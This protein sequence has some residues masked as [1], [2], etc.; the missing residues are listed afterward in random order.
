LSI[1]A[2]IIPKKGD[3]L[4]LWAL[5]EDE[6]F[7]RTQLPDHVIVE[8][9]SFQDPLRRTQWLAVR[10]LLK[11]MGYPFEISYLE[12]GQ[13]QID[14]HCLSIS[15]T[16]KMVGVYVSLEKQGLDLE[17]PHPRI[18]RIAQRFMNTDEQKRFGSSDLDV[19]T[20]IW[21][22]KEALFKKY[23]EETTFFAS[24]Q[25]VLSINHETHELLTEVRLNGKTISE[26]LHFRQ[27]LDH[28][29]VFSA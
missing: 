17:L 29:L 16:P 9:Q 25:N 7:F 15:H 13:P 4:F 6:A 12:S 1:L 2:K 14:K 26:P 23:G 10:Y 20:L 3:N 19:L 28:Y 22:A 18:L 8:C 24:N 11:T 21:S 5:D 27:I